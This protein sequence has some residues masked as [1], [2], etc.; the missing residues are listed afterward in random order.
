MAKHFSI[1]SNTYTQIVYK[2]RMITGGIRDPLERINAIPIDFENKTVL[3]LG[4]NNGGTLFAIADKIKQGWGNDINPEAINIANSVVN[5]YK[6][7]NL[8]FKVADLNNWKEENL[9]KT[10]ILFALAI[11]KWIPTWKDIIK[12]L[13]PK[14]CVFEAHGKKQMIPNQIEWLNSHFKKVDLLKEGYED[15]K[16]KLFLCTQ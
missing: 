8:S 14:I 12:Y 7:P 2:E 16:R 11:A 3:D 6:I 4:C 15:G 1:F 13:D 5:D 9:P 10:D